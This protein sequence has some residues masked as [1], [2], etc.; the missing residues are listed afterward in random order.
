MRGT[1]I[2]DVRYVAAAVACLGLKWCDR[3]RLRLFGKSRTS[4]NDDGSTVVLREWRGREYL[5]N[6]E[7]PPHA[8]SS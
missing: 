8:P 4:R 5:W 7:R 6:F 3:W 1:T 2:G